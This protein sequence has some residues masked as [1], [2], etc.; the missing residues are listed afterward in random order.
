LR[1]DVVPEVADVPSL[2]DALAEHVAGLRATGQLPPPRKKRR[3]RRKA[4]GE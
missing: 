3:V 2:V 4:A 1:V